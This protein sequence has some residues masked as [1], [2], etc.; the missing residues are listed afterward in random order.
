MSHFY[1]RIFPNR[2]GVHS[3]S[4]V[5][6]RYLT[7]PA[8]QVLYRMIQTAMTM[9]HFKCRNIFCQG[10]KLVAQANAKNR[11]VFFQNLLNGFDRISHS[12]RITRPVRK[13][14]AGGAKCLERSQG[15]SSWKYF[16]KGTS[17]NHTMHNIPLHSVIQHSYSYLRRR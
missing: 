16:Y 12:S 8:N 11:L 2:E 14:I 3:K 9:V 15:C 5:L 7:F 13:K 17:F 4:M 10:E 6:S 1:F